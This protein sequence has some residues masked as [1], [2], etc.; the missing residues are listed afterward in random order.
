MSR[1]LGDVYKRQACHTG[2]LSRG[3]IAGIDCS[4]FAVLQHRPVTPPHSCPPLKRGE[5]D[6]S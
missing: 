1:G 2:A 5:Q 6:L 3:I 4:A